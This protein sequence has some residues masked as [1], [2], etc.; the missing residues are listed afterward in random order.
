[1][2]KISASDAKLSNGRKGFTLVEL[3]MT[4]AILAYVLC[5]ILALFV[6]CMFLNEG[7][8]NSSI[9]IGHAQF[10]LEEKKNTAFASITSETWNTAAISA[11]GLAPLIGESIGIVV[12][13]VEPKD[14]NVTVTWRDRNLRN[15]SVNLRTLIT[16]L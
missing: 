5:G 13:G 3:L 6:N 16:E 1:M 9:A 8:R 11:K 15:R 2:I 10:A 4:A 12:S 7:N 14:V